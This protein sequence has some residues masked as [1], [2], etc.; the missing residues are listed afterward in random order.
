MP[1]LGTLTSITGKKEKD[2]FV[3]GGMGAWGF[4]YAPFYAEIL[5]QKILNEPIIVNEK[6]E[7]LLNIDRLI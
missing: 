3:L 5:V 6:I 1:F 2:I 4:V 7:K